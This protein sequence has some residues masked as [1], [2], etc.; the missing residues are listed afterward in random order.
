MT[1]QKAHHLAPA[2]AL[3][4]FLVTIATTSFGFPQHHENPDAN[5]PHLTHVARWSRITT[6]LT[7]P[8]H[9]RAGRDA[10]RSE[11]IGPSTRK[12]G[13][14]APSKRSAAGVGP[15][16]G[17]DGFTRQVSMTAAGATSSL[18][19]SMD[20][21]GRISEEFRD[22][23][24]ALESLKSGAITNDQL[25]GFS[26][27]A[28][29]WRDYDYDASD[30]WIR[31][32]DGSDD[33]QQAWFPEPDLAN[34]Y[35]SFGGELALYDPDGRLLETDNKLFTYDAFGRVASILDPQRGYC[36]YQHDAFGRR[37]SETCDGEGSTGDYTETDFGWDGNNLVAELEGDALFV[38]IHAGGL[39]TP[40]AR[41]SDDNTVYLIQGSD[42][43]VRAA[44]DDDGEVIETYTYTAYGETR[45]DVID[46]QERTGNRLAYHGHIYD[47][48][49]A[50]YS[51]RARV[52]SPKWGRFLSQDPIGVAGGA[53]MYAF[54]GNSPL[55]N[56]DPLGLAP[57]ANPNAGDF[58]KDYSPAG[59]GPRRE[60]E[61]WIKNGSTGEV[62]TRSAARR[63]DNASR[64][65]NSP[66]FLKEISR[67]VAPGALRPYTAPP[68]LPA[69]MAQ[70]IQAQNT[71]ASSASH[72]LFRETTI[73]VGG[74]ATA[75]YGVQLGVMGGGIVAAEVGPA[76]VAAVSAAASSASGSLS[77]AAAEVGRQ[78]AGRLPGWMARM[79]IPGAA[80]GAAVNQAQSGARH[81]GSAAAGVPFNQI[82]G[83]RGLFHSFG[84]H[85]AQ[86]FGRQV[87]SGTHMSA[88]QSLVERAAAST[89]TVPWS[90]GDSATVGHF[91]RIGG[92]PFFAQFYQS[93]PRAGELATAF[94]PNQSQLT[95]ILNL[96]KSK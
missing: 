81:L 88:W 17:Q 18:L 45:I 57:G 90:V 51:M 5:Q 41:V 27:T 74:T 22:V 15:K 25:T 40:I 59:G 49:P 92:K 37:I 38:T 91:A 85:S 71:A 70:H 31:Q 13:W 63:L 35:Q 82:A 52:Y 73:V 95:Q 39:N 75:V 64:R 23:P 32:G 80:T 42:R 65:G 86:W 79:M 94:V 29:A 3:L 43:S 1:W 28:G 2:I 54:V 8:S 7:G 87:S 21:A 14:V 66:T 11:S 60:E 72:N 44:F 84:R 33:D 6:Q 26:E 12:G 48:V 16:Y 47:E 36:E 83:T 46:G 10:S 69:G 68:G 30:N 93:G 55:D 77:Y 53:N 4:T 50:L 56:W 76:A 89:K 9:A 61:T 20:E 62:M 19:A 58:D 96:L 24:G 78:V 34:A 67:F